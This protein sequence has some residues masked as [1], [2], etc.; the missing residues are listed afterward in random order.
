MIQALQKAVVTRLV[1]PLLMWYLR[2]DRKTN[3]KGHTLIVK[4]G[5]FHPAFFFSSA[6]M[7]EAL[8]GL[9]LQGRS[10]LDLG[11]GSGAL[12]VYARGRGARVTAVDVSPLAVEN[13]QLNLERQSSTMPFTV[14][15]SDLFSAIEPREFDVI[16]INPPYYPK[17]PKNDEEK[18]WFCGEDHVYF[19]R[20]FADL[21]PY[22]SRST[23][24]LMTLSEE[25]AI[26]TIGELA[27]AEG[28]RFERSI[29]KRTGWEVHYVYR[30]SIY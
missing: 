24:V 28:F 22:M 8:E 12:S 16:A 11:S 6:L 13:T 4:R 19:K 30:I 15:Q 18:A 1:R 14:I 2:S 7:V 27:A 23:D 29:A 26:D 25:C 17:A 9:D 21:R 5:V 3:F 20:L 10:F